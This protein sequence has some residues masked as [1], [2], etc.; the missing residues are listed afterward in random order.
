MRSIF[1]DCSVHAVQLQ[2]AQTGF[3]M[4]AG[5]R[6]DFSIRH[7]L[8]WRLQPDYLTSAAALG[9][10]HVRASTGIVWRLGG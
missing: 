6:V 8:A 7:N 10:N 3:A 5:G 4:A 9:Q 2:V 1:N